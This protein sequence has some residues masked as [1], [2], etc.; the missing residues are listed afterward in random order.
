M[1]RLSNSITINR[2]LEEVFAY[3]CD[4]RN[5][6]NW[7]YFIIKV[8]KLNE[9]EGGGATYLQTRK[10]DQQQVKIA[11]LVQ[12]ERCVVETLPGQ[13]PKVR[14][15]ME[16]FGDAKSTTIKDQLDLL[17]PIPKF[18]SKWLG[19]RPSNAVHENLNKLKELLERGHV[20]LQ[21]GRE[22][23]LQ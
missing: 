6:P 13:K 20:V 15:E 4:Q 10:T 5:N 3:V 19:R 14:R 7:N 22:V 2:P 12:N 1:I 21:D 18:L 11:D 17:L 9:K 23:I 16:F 8:E